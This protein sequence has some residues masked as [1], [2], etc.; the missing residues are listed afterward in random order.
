MALNAER[1]QRIR[2]LVDRE[3]IADLLHEYCRCIDNLD[4]AGVAAVF[5]EDCF[6]DYGPIE[7]AQ[8]R[9]AAVLAEVLGGFQG[10]FARTHHQLSNV[11]I[12]FEAP[13]RAHGVSYVRAWH[14]FPD[15]RPPYVLYAQY[16]DRFVRR[17]A[18]WRISERRLVT[19]G[20]EN[21]DAP[22]HWLVRGA[23]AGG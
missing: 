6:I 4:P 1:D 18:G 5:T 22:R 14:Q 10:R 8:I 21:F 23:P 13:D 3:E 7:S 15:D 20:Q 19:L 12:R 16:H 17:A 11:Q 9:G 2:Q